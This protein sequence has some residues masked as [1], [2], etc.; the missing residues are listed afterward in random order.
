MQERHNVPTIW[1]KGQNVL[2]ELSQQIIYRGSLEDHNNPVILHIGP[3][4]VQKHYERMKR[5]IHSN[6]K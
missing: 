4:A 2:H 1:G 5:Y 6:N 3:A